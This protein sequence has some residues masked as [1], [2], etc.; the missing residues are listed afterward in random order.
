MPVV[1]CDVFITDSGYRESP[2]SALLPDHGSARRRL[3]TR[4]PRNY[5]PTIRLSPLPAFGSASGLF[6]N[7]VIAPR[8][9]AFI[10]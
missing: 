3:A 7:T 4:G 9:A 5:L 1:T 10:V 2:Q 8:N 6:I